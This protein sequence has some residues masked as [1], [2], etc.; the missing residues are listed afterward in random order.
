MD[1]ETNLDAV[2]NV[3]IRQGTYRRCLKS[4]LTGGMVIDVKDLVLTPG[5]YRSPVSRTDAEENYAFKARD[6]A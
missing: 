2:H 5:I 1:P 6:M 3:G 4:P